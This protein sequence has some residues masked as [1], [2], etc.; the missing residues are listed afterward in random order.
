MKATLWLPSETV[1]S[2]STCEPALVNKCQPGQVVDSSPCSASTEAT[3]CCQMRLGWNSSRRFLVLF[4]P[5]AFMADK[6]CLSKFWHCIFSS[7]CTLCLESGSIAN[8]HTYAFILILMRFWQAEIV[9]TV[10]IQQKQAGGKCKMF[11][12]VVHFPATSHGPMNL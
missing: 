11:I 10:I 4:F 5:T 8:T 12:C 9:H 1:S 2:H 6:P 7:S 3:H